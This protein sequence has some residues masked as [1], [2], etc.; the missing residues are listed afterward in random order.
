MIIII[1]I[2]IIIIIIIIVVN[3]DVLI[4]HV[5][6]SRMFSSFTNLLVCLFVLY[7]VQY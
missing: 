2:V 3:A 5:G 1:I 7:K 4:Y 6:T